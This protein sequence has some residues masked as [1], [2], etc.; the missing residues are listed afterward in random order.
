M[1]IIQVDYDL[2]NF[3]TEQFLVKRIFFLTKDSKTTISCG[4]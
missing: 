3:Y 2:K 1:Q 4:I